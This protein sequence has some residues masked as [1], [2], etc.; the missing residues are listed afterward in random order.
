MTDDAALDST[1]PTERVVLYELATLAEA[2]ETPVR[3][4]TVLKRCR[5]RLET[6]DTVVTSR[7]SEAD[8]ARSCRTLA[9][10]GLLERSAAEETSPVGK[11]RPS[12]DVAVD[13]TTVREVVREDERF[14]EFEDG[15]AS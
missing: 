2:D 11:G 6:V 8:V 13:P 15:D 7:V 1:S 10:E 9:D 14:R 12:Y 3:V 5:E 4:P